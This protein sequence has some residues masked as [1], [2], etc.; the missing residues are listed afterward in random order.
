[1]DAAWP[2]RRI[3]SFAAPLGRLSPE[4][5]QRVGEAAELVERA[6]GEQRVGG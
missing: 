6:L 3:A 2:E 4:G 1:M 5:L